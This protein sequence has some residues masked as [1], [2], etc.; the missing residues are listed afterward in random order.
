MGFK[1]YLAEEWSTTIK[2]YPDDIDGHVNADIYEN[3]TRKDIKDILK[4][5]SNMKEVK[6]LYDVDERVLY[7]FD[8][9]LYHEDVA[10]QY[11]ID[12]NIA[13]ALQALTRERQLNIYNFS[14]EAAYI[15]EVMATPEFKEKVLNL[16]KGYRIVI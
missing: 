1:N 2:A 12:H 11:A 7:G 16:F 6:L 3:V 13:I 5:R 9:S 8:Y 15:R 10:Q 4:K 14:G